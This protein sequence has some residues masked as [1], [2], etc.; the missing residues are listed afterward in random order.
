MIEIIQ[1]LPAHV[2]GFRAVGKVTKEDYIKTIIPLVKSVATAFG[3][4][5]Y[6]LVISTPLKNYTT[7]AWIEDALLGFRYFSKWN[8]IAI[9]SEKEG[10]KK[11]TDTFGK[12]V[13]GK[14]KGFN[15]EELSKAK[16]WIA[17]L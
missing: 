7:A 2:T 8:K 12:F 14:T 5:N 6:L 4:I 9:V 1:G 11:F 17:D 15:M 3:K 10:I 16:M 13:P